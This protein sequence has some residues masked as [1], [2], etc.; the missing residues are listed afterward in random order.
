MK[1]QKRN[2]MILLQFFFIVTLSVIASECA[3]ALTTDYVTM[4]EGAI[5]STNPDA[6]WI[7]LR[8][9]WYG[10]Y[11]IPVCKQ[12]TKVEQCNLAMPVCL[13]LQADCQQKTRILFIAPQNQTGASPGTSIWTDDFQLGTSTAAHR[14]IFTYLPQPAGTIPLTVFKDTETAWQRPRPCELLGNASLVG[15]TGINDTPK[16][17]TVTYLNDTF[18]YKPATGYTGTDYFSFVIRDPDVTQLPADC[19]NY[20]YDRIAAHPT[21][22]KYDSRRVTVIVTV[23]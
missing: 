13:T 23:K 1:M 16:H 17:G 22:T 9:N 19:T 2:K 11:D 4:F 14:Y 12:G 3:W 18:K 21:M 6:R 10:C 5:G 7:F 8:G 20:N 15:L